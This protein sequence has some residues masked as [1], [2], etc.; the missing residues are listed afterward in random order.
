M[1]PA[2]PTNLDKF[3]DMLGL[4]SLAQGLVNT[5]ERDTGPLTLS[6]SFVYSKVFR[7]AQ[8]GWL[9]TTRE[10]GTGYDHDRIIF[11]EPEQQGRQ[12]SAEEDTQLAEPASA[13]RRRAK[14]TRRCSCEVASQA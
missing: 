7:G 3:E 14:R 5:A 4:P 9:F 8:P 2:L 1:A 11:P 10:K 12:L 6:G 13:R